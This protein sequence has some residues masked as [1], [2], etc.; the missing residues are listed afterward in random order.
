MEIGSRR[1]LHCNVTEHPTAE[2]TIQ[3]L[4]EFL[5]YDHP[6]RVLLHDRDAIFSS[7]V[8]LALQ[9]FGI[10]VL[11]TPV[12]SPKANAYC[13]RLVGTIR[14]ECLYYLIP[15]NQR[16]LHRIVKEFARYYNRGRSHS[17]LGPGIPEP[18]QSSVPASDHRYQLPSGYR[19]AK[20]PIVGGLHH[21]YRLEKEVA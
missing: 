13:E 2:W 20:R 12:R 4:R 19:I 8:D 16:H 1:I 21:D 17:S 3:Q 6:Y 11:K 10:R 14:R 5:A 7:S 15:I 9:H 18:I